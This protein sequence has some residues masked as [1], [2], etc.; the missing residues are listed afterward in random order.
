VT[1]RIRHNVAVPIAGAIA[2]VGAVPLASAFFGGTDGTPAYA[3]AMLAIL[4]VPLAVIVW[5]WRSGTDADPDGL[6]L[7]ALAGTRRVPW[8]RV[9]ALVPQG[10]RVVALLD[11]GRGV[12]L[13]AVT[14]S[15]LPRLVA[16]SGS[17]LDEPAG[18]AADAEPGQ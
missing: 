13:P 4:L 6:R 17:P 8:S 1:V 16:A 5:G 12:T 2:F 11:D 14:R 15:D 3:Y 7:R 18:D 9:R 10:R